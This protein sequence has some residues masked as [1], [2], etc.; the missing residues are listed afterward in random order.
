MLSDAL[1]HKTARLSVL[2]RRSKMLRTL[3][4]FR[5]TADCEDDFSNEEFHSEMRMLA[6]IQRK[7]G[8][9]DSKIQALMTGAEQSSSDSE[10]DGEKDDLR[11]LKN[12]RQNLRYALGEGSV[13]AA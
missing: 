9:L 11:K 1:Q 10:G 7:L 12:A 4:L 13:P 5:D 6:T 3:W 2:R 8:G